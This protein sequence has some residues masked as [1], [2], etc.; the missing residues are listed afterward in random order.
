MNRHNY[1]FA[2]RLII[3]CTA[4]FPLLAGAQE[5]GAAAA[6]YNAGVDAYFRGRLAEAESSFSKLIRIDP[7]DPRA[8]YFR[9]LTLSQQG[10]SNEARADMQLGAQ[11][12]A[13]LPNRF[14]IGKT[15]ER[16][17]GPTRLELEQ[18]RSR[19]RQSVAMNPPRGPVRSPDAAVLREHRI[20]PLDEFSRSGQ[21]QSIVAPEPLPEVL[22]QSIPATA[23]PVQKIDGASA[24]DADPFKKEDAGP[25]PKPQPK[26]P[27]KT[28][29]DKTPTKAALPKAPKPTPPAPKPAEGEQGDPFL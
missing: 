3:G 2:I 23:Q 4:V 10:R 16:V 21:P 20:V 22:K 11:I 1:Q 17:Q 28:T 12:E 19:A 25:T 27:P 26:T 9:A 6:L 29:P 15:L 24:A 8:F 5:F 18:Y 14:D 13:R 7:N